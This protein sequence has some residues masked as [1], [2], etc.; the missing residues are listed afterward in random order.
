MPANRSAVSLMCALRAVGSP[1]I[2]FAYWNGLQISQYAT[3]IKSS[4]LVEPFARLTAALY[5]PPKYAQGM[6]FSLNAS[7]MVRTLDG[8]TNVPLARNW[9]FGRKAGFTLFSM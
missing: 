8:G 6:F 1:M 7:P 9:P 4:S 3:P 5:A 2:D